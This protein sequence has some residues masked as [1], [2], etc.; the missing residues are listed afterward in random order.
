MTSSSNTTRFR[1][2]I[3]T[4]YTYS[5][6]F[7]YKFNWPSEHNAN[8]VHKINVSVFINT[9]FINKCLFFLLLILSDCLD[10]LTWID[11]N[12]LGFCDTKPLTFKF[13][14]GNSVKLQYKKYRSLKSRAIMI[15]ALF[16][17]RIGRT[18]SHPN[19]YVTSLERN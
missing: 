17:N 2:L 11:I 18:H 4:F 5:Y 10:K 7:I 6:P 14:N 19:T 16:G 8:L 1:R 12:L 3:I 13:D 15:Q 9:V